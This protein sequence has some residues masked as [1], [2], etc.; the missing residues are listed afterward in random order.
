MQKLEKGSKKECLHGSW[1]ILFLGSR[2]LY[3]CHLFP[4]SAVYCLPCIGLYVDVLI[5]QLPW[6]KDIL[7]PRTTDSPS[8]AFSS[9]MMITRRMSV[10]RCV[11]VYSC[12]PQKVNTPFPCNRIFW[13]VHCF[14]V[15]GS[16]SVQTSK[17][18]VDSISRPFCLVFSHATEMGA[19][20]FWL[21][22]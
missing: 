11:W 21:L 12:S 22:L 8:S 3:N 19:L 17:F 6:L 20:T 7:F 1:N 5:M 2:R 4:C 9:D 14:H 15:L 18:R 16:A 10:S 13:L